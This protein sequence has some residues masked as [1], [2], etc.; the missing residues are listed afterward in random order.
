M[1]QWHHSVVAE[2][3]TGSLGSSTEGGLFST[4][5]HLG[6][7]VCWCCSESICRCSARRWSRWCCWR[8]SSSAES[9]R[10]GSGSDCE[11]RNR[12]SRHDSEFGEATCEL[13][14]DMPIWGMLFVIVLPGC[15]RARRD[16]RNGREFCNSRASNDRHQVTVHELEGGSTHP[17][18]FGVTTRDGSF[19][20]VKNGATG[21]LWLSPGAIL[22]H[23]AIRG[24]SRCEFRSNTP[25]PIRRRSRSPGPP[26]TPTCRWMFLPTRPPSPIFFA[27]A[28]AGKWNYSMQHQQIAGRRSMVAAGQLGF[29]GADRLLRPRRR[30]RQQGQTGLTRWWWDL[31]NSSG[32]WG[33][34]LRRELRATFVS[35]GLCLPMLLLP[36]ISQTHVTPAW[37]GCE[38]N[39][40]TASSGRSLSAASPKCRSHAH[41]TGILSPSDGFSRLAAGDGGRN[42]NC[43]PS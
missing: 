29:A 9:R 36:A 41:S 26:A 39:S 22:L 37:S 3:G 5:F 16:R 15:G 1:R 33:R 8:S 18:G 35:L 30:D 27:G 12:R 42:P 6:W 11:V 40:P 17:V 28:A 13:W 31:V 24:Q 10:S 7:S 21:P 25:S 19:K 32:L 2:A 4:V 23:A 20:L 43:S 34:P 38:A 14:A